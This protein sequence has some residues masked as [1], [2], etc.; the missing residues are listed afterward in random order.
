MFCTELSYGGRASI[1]MDRIAL[2][3]A[4]LLMLTLWYL[5]R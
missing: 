4:I 2:A 5:G 3:V 1:T